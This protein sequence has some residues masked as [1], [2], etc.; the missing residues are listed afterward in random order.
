MRIEIDRTKILSSLLWNEPWRDVERIPR[1]IPN[2][3]TRIY[4][5]SFVRRSIAAMLST[6]NRR[7]VS[8]R[9]SPPE[10]QIRR[11]PNPLVFSHR[12]D[13]SLNYLTVIS[14]LLWTTLDCA[15]TTERPDTG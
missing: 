3:L 2:L 14:P 7:D 11:F 6:E 9:I 13:L 4:L 5:P 15:C 12:R 8:G 10:L 1:A